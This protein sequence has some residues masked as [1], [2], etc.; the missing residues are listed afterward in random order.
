M[1]PFVYHQLVI[2]GW[3]ILFGFM[4]CLSYDILRA[5]RR[6]IPHHKTAVGIEDL[7]F[8]IIAGF[9]LFFYIFYSNNGAMRAFILIGILIGGILYLTILSSWIL[10]FMTKVFQF[11]LIGFIKP[12]LI[13]LKQIQNF[14]KII[15]KGLKKS[16]K[17]L[18]MK[19][20]GLLKQVYTIVKKV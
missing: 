14:F 16:H 11:I 3:A 17:W 12:I 15:H 1:N 10:Y 5:I 20:R 9:G 4:L 19:I 18:I 7:I 2:F 13:L 8:W 6:V